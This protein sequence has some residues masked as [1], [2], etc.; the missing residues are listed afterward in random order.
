MDMPARRID[1][2]RHVLVRILGF[3]EQQLGAD[4][5]RHV[6]VHRADNEDDPLLQQAGVDI[7][8]PLAAIGLLDHH[9]HQ[10]IV[11][12]LDRIPILH[13]VLTIPCPVATTA[14]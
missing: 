6:V 10:Q 11:V 7:E 5:A 3:E 13:H 2:E 12:D 4:Q 9:R 1:V 8:C 14:A